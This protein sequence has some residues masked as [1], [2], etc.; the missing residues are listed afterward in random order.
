MRKRLS[1]LDKLLDKLGLIMLI[2][3]VVFFLIAKASR[4]ERIIKAP[5]DKRVTVKGFVE[6]IQANDEGTVIKLYEYNEESIYWIY[7]EPPLNEEY[8][9]IEIGDL[10]NVTGYDI[11]GFDENRVRAEH[12]KI[13]KN[14]VE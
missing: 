9:H 8:S 6:K 5:F 10:M 3:I 12:L 11:E 4:L 2:G 14:E 7:L 13:S 1:W